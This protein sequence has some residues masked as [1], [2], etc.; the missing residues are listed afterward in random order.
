MFMSETDNSMLNFIKQRSETLKKNPNQPFSK[1][2]NFEKYEQ[3]YYG[4]QSDT[5]C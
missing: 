2:D 4:V 1:I 5:E 3:E